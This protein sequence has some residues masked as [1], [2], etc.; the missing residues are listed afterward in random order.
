MHRYLALLFMQ[1]NPDGVFPMAVEAGNMLSVGDTTGE[2]FRVLLSKT[3]ESI[4]KDR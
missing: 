4:E 1:A 3:L 2:I